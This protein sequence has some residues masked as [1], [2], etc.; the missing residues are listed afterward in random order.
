MT[1][2]TTGLDTATVYAVGAIVAVIGWPLALETATTIW[3]PS[4]ADRGITS[5]VTNRG[6]AWRAARV[7]VAIT[8]GFIV[9]MTIPVGAMVSGPAFAASLAAATWL[10]IL[11]ID[12]D[13][14]SQKIPRE[15]P[16]MTLALILLAGTVTS[17]TWTLA[18]TVILT[19]VLVYGFFTVL[20]VFTRGLGGGDILVFTGLTGLTWYTGLDGLLTGIMLAATIQVAVHVGYYLIRRSWTRVLPFGPAITTGMTA[21]AFL[22]ALVSI[23]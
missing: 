4:W 3:A 15:P 7:A 17:F 12:T 23:T 8:A 1:I 2:T 5:R 13:T 19:V 20:A 6:I 10:T 11:V 22:T 14:V 16:L 21:G 9:L 18:L